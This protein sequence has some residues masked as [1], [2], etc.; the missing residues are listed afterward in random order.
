MTAN[1]GED[2]RVL[3]QASRL[4]AAPGDLEKGGA[5]REGALARPGPAGSG[6][7]GPR[8]SRP[9]TGS[10]MLFLTNITLAHAG[11]YECEAS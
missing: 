2:L 6:V 1:L 8:R 7:A 11:K 9:D 5:A 4:P 10:G 3:R